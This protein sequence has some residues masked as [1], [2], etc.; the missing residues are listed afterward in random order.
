MYVKFVVTYQKK[1][2]HS[3]IHITPKHMHTFQVLHAVKGY[4][5]L[6]DMFL[7]YFNCTNF[8][9]VALVLRWFLY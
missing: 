8:K 4:G 3:R 1:K 6:S 7:T 9:P 2:L 5:L